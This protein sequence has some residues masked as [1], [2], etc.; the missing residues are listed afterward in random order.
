MVA[1]AAEL[2][3]LQGL[4][5]AH[6]RQVERLQLHLHD[7]CDRVVAAVSTVLDARDASIR[8]HSDAVMASAARVAGELGLSVAQVEAVVL[9]ARLHD[10]G[11]VGVTGSLL[12]KR[13]P[14]DTRER[15]LMQ[16]H[17]EL[18]FRLLDGLPLPTGTALAVRHHHERYDGL[19]YPDGLAG[20]Q[21]PLASRIICVVD[22]FDAMVADR[23]YRERLSPA[24]A[25]Q[26][27]A[28]CSGSHFCPR[29]VQAFLR[30]SQPPRFGELAA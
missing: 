29:V 14:L 21:I 28:R 12:G 6:V 23:P 10:I 16:R 4:L 11:K 24:A 8:T 26:E 20:E 3:A 13:G 22:A 15:R 7:L 2:P 9:A 1:P 18:G 30:M 27:I 25:R 5:T 17:A 19:G